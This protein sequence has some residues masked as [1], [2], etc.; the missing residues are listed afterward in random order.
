MSTWVVSHTHTN[1]N[2]TVN[3]LQFSSKILH[4]TLISSFTFAH[5]GTVHYSLFTSASTTLLIVFSR[6]FTF[7]FVGGKYLKFDLRIEKKL[8]IQLETRRTPKAGEAYQG[9]MAHRRCA[10]LIYPMVRVRSRIRDL[11][12][13]I[14]GIACP[15][16]VCYQ[17]I[18][19]AISEY[20]LAQRHNRQ[21][22]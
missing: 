11:R 14:F 17:F 9:Q 20:L 3:L 8:G 22:G 7:W 16:C 12:R 1:T 15:P 6:I 4:C 13:R 10:S 2:F 5:I 19:A 21:L 18:T